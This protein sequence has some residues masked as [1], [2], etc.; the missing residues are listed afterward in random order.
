MLKNNIKT[1]SAVI[2]LS[3][4]HDMRE[5]QWL[6]AE[7]KFTGLISGYNGLFSLVL[8]DELILNAIL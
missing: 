8:N 2:C 5:K 3:Q 6:V 1:I 4:A 7:D